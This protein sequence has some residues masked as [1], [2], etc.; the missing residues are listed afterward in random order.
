MGVTPAV[1][2]GIL[3]TI[4]PVEAAVTHPVAVYTDVGLKKSNLNQGIW[5]L[6]ATLLYISCT[7]LGKASGPDPASI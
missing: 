5:V 1:C 2:V 7:A 6:L 3:T 4:Q